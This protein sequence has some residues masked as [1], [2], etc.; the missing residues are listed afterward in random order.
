MIKYI[1]GA[2]LG[3][4]FLYFWVSF[5]VWEFPISFAELERGDR[6]AFVFFSLCFAVVGAICAV[7][8]CEECE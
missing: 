5:T 7:D 4:A 3:A 2:V 6:F 1:I 8:L